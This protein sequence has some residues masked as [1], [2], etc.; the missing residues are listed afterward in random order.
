MTGAS[1]ERIALNRVTFG[2]RDVDVALVQ[3]NGWTQWVADQL[4]PPKGDDPALEIGRA[5]V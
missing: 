2:A 3:Q 5:H 4:A 1:F